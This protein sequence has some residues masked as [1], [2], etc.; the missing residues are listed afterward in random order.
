M[1]FPSYLELCRLTWRQY[2]VR[3]DLILGLTLLIALPTHLIISL[4]LPE[5]PALGEVTTAG[6]LF[7]IIITDPK[8][9]AMLAWNVLSSALL[10]ILT[11]ALM[12]VLRASYQRRSLRLQ[13]IF[14]ATARYYFKILVTS[15]LVGCLTAI[16]LVLFIV[17]GIIIGVYLS[18]ALPVVVWE[19]K[20][21]IAALRRSI[22]LV[23]G[24]ARYVFIYILMTELLLSMIIWVL[25]S[26]LPLTLPFE[27]FSLSVSSLINAFAIF[28][29][30]VLYTAC[31]T[32]W[33]AEKMMTKVKTAAVANPESTKPEPKL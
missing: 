26:I 11:T 3:F 2:L 14:Q 16:G 4:V 22:E 6:E 1:Q 25:I 8:I 21:P 10:L 7:Q 28:F 33:N 23:R 24:Q 5:I 30:T 15:I 13:L 31:A 19:N 32:W 20:S 29:E 12:V 18:L 9:W 17:P 27:V